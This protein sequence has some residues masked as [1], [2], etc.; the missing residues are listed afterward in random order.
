METDRIGLICYAH[1]PQS[2]S[3]PTLK[4]SLYYPF[5]SMST[6]LAARFPKTIYDHSVKDDQRRGIRQIICQLLG[7]AE[8][9]HTGT[10]SETQAKSLEKPPQPSG[11][12]EGA[13]ALNKLKHLL[14]YVC[15]ANGR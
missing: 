2:L 1:S 10:G 8:S 14:L 4:L 11:C 5:T 13:M 7:S 9:L 3:Q 15:I 6:E 12:F